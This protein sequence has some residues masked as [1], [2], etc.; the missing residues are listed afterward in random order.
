MS[1]AQAMLGTRARYLVA[2]IGSAA[3]VAVLLSYPEFFRGTP[4]LLA[5]SISLVVLLLVGVGPAVLTQTSLLAAS[6]YVAVEPYGSFSIASRADVGRLTIFAG[7]LLLANLLAARHERT[8]AEAGARERLLRRTEA[9]YRHVFE[10]A[11]DGI[12]LASPDG[13]LRLANR[14]L[15][16]MLG[17]SGEELL[18]LPLSSLYDSSDLQQAPPRM[19]RTRS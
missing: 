6:V 15:S 14:R 2:A 18:Q 13:R 8:R 4:Y 16:E 11:S 12:V 1:D 10:E 9:R 17:Y 5:G 7:F 19:E 3:G